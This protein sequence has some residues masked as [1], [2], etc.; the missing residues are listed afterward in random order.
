MALKLV[1]AQKGGR[2]GAVSADSMVEE[3]SGSYA[4][5]ED[6]QN[7]RMLCLLLV[8]LCSRVRP[9]PLVCY[10]LVMQVVRSGVL[11]FS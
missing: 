2:N 11:V 5:E 4:V 6:T 7:L 1:V 10:Q 8:W 9:S 3:V